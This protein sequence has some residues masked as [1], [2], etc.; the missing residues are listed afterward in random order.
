MSTVSAPESIAPW[1]NGYSSGT[2]TLLAR[3]A[4][5]QRMPHDA[6]TLHHRRTLEESTGASGKEE[7]HGASLRSQCRC[8][9]VERSSPPASRPG[10][11][12]SARCWWVAQVGESPVLRLWM[13]GFLNIIWDIAPSR[14]WG[15]T[16]TSARE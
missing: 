9:I 4:R 16:L 6:T 14:N 1:I 3:A 2:V 15:I 7:V 13:C 11:S 12:V 8:S 10:E 5:A